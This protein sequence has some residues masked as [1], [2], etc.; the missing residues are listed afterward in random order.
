MFLKSM[1]IH[2]NVLKSNCVGGEG[3]GLNNGVELL[4]ILP[5]TGRYWSLPDPQVK[6]P[7][8]KIIMDAIFKL[9]GNF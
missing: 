6:T 7:S 3:Q 5:S 9:N 2:A 1:K 4:L 8:K